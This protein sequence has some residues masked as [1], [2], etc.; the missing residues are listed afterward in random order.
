MMVVARTGSGA[1]EMHSSVSLVVHRPRAISS[2][3]QLI[4]NGCP[5]NFGDEKHIESTTDNWEVGSHKTVAYY[6][7]TVS[8]RHR[9]VISR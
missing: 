9:K 7:V 6:S 3:Y 4:P 5:G 1:S 2:H 8:T